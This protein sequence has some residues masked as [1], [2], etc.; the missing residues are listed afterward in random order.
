MLRKR[1]NE[2]HAPLGYNKKH[3]SVPKECRT[4]PVLMSSVQCPREAKLCER[5]TNFAQIFVVYAGKCPN[6][7]VIYKVILPK[8]RENIQMIKEMVINTL[9]LK[10]N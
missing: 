6:R 2:K 4:K 9:L 1:E 8:L 10:K 5:T 3:F 7:I